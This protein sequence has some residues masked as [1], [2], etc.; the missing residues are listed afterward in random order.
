MPPSK[1]FLG[2]IHR[3]GEFVPE[4]AAKAM[5]WFRRA[6][7]QGDADAQL[8]LSLMYRK[9]EFVP[10]DAAEA[11]RWC[12]KAAEQGDVR[13]QHNLCQWFNLEM[14]GTL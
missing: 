12:R 5:K 3:K 7:E 6:A 14:A 8:Y 10:E 11:V 1:H 4:D 9:G 13:A 2:R